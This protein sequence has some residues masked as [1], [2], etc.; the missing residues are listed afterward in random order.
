MPAFRDLTGQTFGRLTVI[1]RVAALNSNATWRCRCECGGGKIVRGHAL[2]R[3]AT[4][5]CGCLYREHAGNL[6]R[7]H[8]LTD[9]REYR[10]WSQMKGRCFNPRVEMYPHYGGRGIT[11]CARWRDSFEAFLADMGHCPTGFWIERNDPDG[12]YEPGNCRWATP[13]E[14][15][16][17]RRNTLRLTLNGRTQ[18]IGDWAEETGLSVATIRG[19]CRMGWPD[20]RTLTTLRDARAKP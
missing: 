10:A 4:R 18:A 8:S 7:T 12:N 9:T 16:R 1:E 14:Q 17:N 5:S 19:R 2:T 3:G 15:Q 20:E 6:N 11:V 13:K